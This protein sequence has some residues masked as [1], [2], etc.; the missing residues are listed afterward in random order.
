[1]DKNPSAACR[2]S[3]WVEHYCCEADYVLLC[4]RD[5]ERTISA[6]RLN[7]EIN[8]M[9]RKVVTVISALSAVLAISALAQAQTGTGQHTGLVN[10]GFEEPRV[11]EASVE[12]IE[13]MPGWKTTDT[14]FEIWS[15]GFKEVKAYE[16]TQ[17]GEL[18]AYI[19]GTLFQDSTG[20][21]AGSL[22]E[23]TFAH[24]G[25]SGLDTMRLTITDLGADNTPEGGDDKVLFTHD[26]TTGND[27][28]KVYT[29]TTEEPIKALGNTVRFAYGAVS[30]ATGELGEGNLLDA[31]NFGI[32]VVTHKHEVAGVN[33]TFTDDG[34]DTTAT[35]SGSL[36]ITGFEKPTR[37]EYPPGIIHYIVPSAGMFG[38]APDRGSVL[39]GWNRMKITRSTGGAGAVGRGYGTGAGMHIP[40]GKHSGDIFVFQLNSNGLYLPQNYASGA[41]ISG[42]VVYP[43]VTV[44]ALGVV[45][46]E[47]TL[48]D[49]QIIRIQVNE[50]PPA[51]A[52]KLDVTGGAF[53]FGYRT[54]EQPDFTEFPNTDS[55]HEGIMRRN[56]TEIDPF[57][58]FAQNTGDTELKAQ[59]TDLVHY[60]AKTEGSGVLHPGPKKGDVAIA[61]FRAEKEG[62]YHFKIGAQLIEEDP[63]GAGVTIY[64]DDKIVD[65]TH[66]TGHLVPWISSPVVKLTVG[67]TVDIAVD[68]GPD[69]AYQ[70]DHVLLSA[71]AWTTNEVVALETPPA[72]PAD[73]KKLDIDSGP[74]TFGYSTTEET[75]FHQFTETDYPFPKDRNIKRLHR[76]GVDWFSFVQNTGDTPSDPKNTSTVHYP[77]K[78][79]G[80]GVLHPGPNPGDVAMARFTAESEGE[81]HFNITSTVIAEKPTGVGVT[82]SVGNE[83][84]VEVV[85]KKHMTEHHVPWIKSFSRTLKR[86]DTVDIAVDNGEGKNWAL[87]HVL[88]TPVWWTTP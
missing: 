49:G 54:A 58:S 31:A 57:F 43:G 20:I 27:E 47:Y 86:G 37:Y 56:V 3:G 21:Q 18:N 9:I 48:P 10:P 13:K 75:G 2:V 76:K 52:M 66:L 12:L 64:V 69:G 19:H 53:K 70:K 55:P 11:K 85:D 16:G 6:R 5:R 14:H 8:S 7:P 81:Y 29:S 59:E 87:D 23:F 67:Q 63:T 38:L 34:T 45:P 82:I 4:V 22:L 25:R 80:S 41:E 33:I 77:A 17:F 26:Y 40:R 72:P 84:G 74:F 1:M 30:T 15:T 68:N 71:K 24:R 28:W 39:F 44:A 35:I 32:G 73:A 62:L 65:Q 88:V 61:R 50:T 78:D 46:T 36:D 83:A 42:Q 79:E 60:P 51:N